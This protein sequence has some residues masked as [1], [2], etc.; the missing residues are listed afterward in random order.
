MGDNGRYY[1]PPTVLDVYRHT[2]CPIA[3]LCLPNQ[4]EMQELTGVDIKSIA[5][6]SRALDALHAMGVQNAVITSMTLQDQEDVL[7]LVARPQDGD[8]F[9][10]RML[11]YPHQF[12]GTGDLL[13]ALVLHHHHTTSLQEACERAVSTVHAVIRATMDKQQ[14]ELALVQNAD[15]VLHPTLDFKA[16]RITE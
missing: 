16:Q 15:A 3:Y 2:L 13:S 6:A 12:S 14:V 1:V 8:A 10:I 11:K 5:D 9:T 4:F 7:W